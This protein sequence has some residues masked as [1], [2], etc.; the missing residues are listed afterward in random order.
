MTQL[1]QNRPEPTTEKEVLQQ[2]ADTKVNVKEAWA[3]Y[4]TICICSQFY[5]N[6]ASINGWYPSFAAFG[7]EQEH[8]FFKNRTAAQA[9]L[10][11]TNMNNADSMD[12]AFVADS[13][14]LQISAPAPNIEGVINGGDGVS[15]E[16][17]WPDSLCGHVFSHDLPYHMGCEFVTQQDIRLQNTCYATPPGYGAMTSGVA[18]PQDDGT[19]LAAYG[20]LPFSGM[21]V[22]Q[23]VPLLKNRFPFPEPIGIPR[24]STIEVRLKLSEIA[25]EYLTS[26][27]GPRDYVFNSA[28]GLAPY[29]FFPKR[30][31]IQASLIGTRMVQQ[32]G[33]YFR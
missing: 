27:L 23:G 8:I 12:F 29:S 14:G 15:G 24:T 5:G 18:Y 16:V 4:D 25:R 28:D 30:Y 3:I 20:Q 19:S 32:R 33:Q 17:K 13:I 10:A 6:E 31:M 11:Y 9:S 26:M 2:W 22:N 1:I 7:A 21:V